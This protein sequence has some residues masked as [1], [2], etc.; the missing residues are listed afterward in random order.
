MGLNALMDRRGPVFSDR[1]HAHP[2][3]TPTEVRNALT[4]VLGNFSS[5][6]ARRGDA[7]PD[8]Y[9]DRY[10]S[11]ATRCPDG[12]L[13]PVT[14]PRTWLMRV[15][16]DRGRRSHAGKGPPNQVTVSDICRDGAPGRAE[17]SVVGELTKL[18]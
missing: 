5:H 7:L 17:G 12:E 2:L 18:S 4:Y 10:S 13:P 15:E 16:A 6:A 1:Y 3:R 8:G 14:V 9:V 11:A